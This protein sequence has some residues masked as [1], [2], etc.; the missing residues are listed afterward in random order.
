MDDRERL[1]PL[2]VGSALAITVAIAYVL[3]AA[4]WAIWRE[5]AL[6]FLNALFHRIAPKRIEMASFIRRTVPTALLLTLLFMGSAMAAESGQ[7]ARVNG[8]DVFYGVIPAEIVSGHPSGH[9]ET[10]M[11][12]GV[13]RGSGQH[14]LIV[15]V[16]D[17][18]SGKRIENAQVSARVSELALTP[19]SKNLE[20][21]QIAGT[22]T[23]GNFFTMTSPG[24]YRIEVD[25]R[26]HGGVPAQAVFEYRH[27][28]R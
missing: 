28:R 26:P 18:K 23:Y 5:A 27:P 21:M 1:S 2:L 6:D 10:K 22:V 17:V 3:C 13:P 24:P 4:A 25:V 16:F 12:G 9:T 7:V 11:H 20:P 14:H 19:Q 15:S 8:M